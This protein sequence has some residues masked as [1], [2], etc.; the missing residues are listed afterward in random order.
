[1]SVTKIVRLMDIQD[2]ILKNNP[3]ANIE[4]LHMGYVYAAQ[5]HRGQ[6]RQ[7]GEAY[8]S[9]PLNVAYILAEMKMDVDSI[10][11]GLL[12]DTIEDTST[13]YE[14]IEE[15]FGKEVA[16]LVEAVTKISKIPFQSKEEKQ[17][18]SFRKML[19]SMSDD[20]RVII[21]K[22]ADRLHNMRTIDSLREDKQKRIA[23]ET[24]DI[25]A[26][27]ADRLGIAWIKW[28]LED[29]A[30]RILTPDM[31]YEI[32]QKVKLKRTE[33]EQYL[34][35]VQD[36]VKDALD[37]SGIKGEISGRPKHFYSIYSKMIKKKTSFEEIFDL[38]ALRV[39]VATKQD[40]YSALGIIHSLWTPIPHRIKDFIANPKANMYQSLHTTV[41]GPGGM[42]VEF[43]IRTKD[44]HQIAEEG[45][46]AHWA[47]KEGR[48]FNPKEDSRFGWLRK[49]LEEDMRNQ[50]PT[51]FVN[52]IKEDVF[53]NQIYV[54]TPKGH[55]VELPEGSTPIDFAYAIHSEV[56][57]KCVG[58]KIN[59][60][61][62]PLK[63]KL[64]S[65]DK[66][67]IMTSQTQE[68]RKDWLNIVQT[69]RARQRI[70]AHLR[71]KESELAIS[72][73][74]ELLNKA[75]K[76]VSLDAESL[77][78]D[79]KNFKKVADKF[80]LKTLEELY[81]NVGFGQISPKK[82]VHL[83]KE[84]EPEDEQDSQS[85]QKSAP[86]TKIEPFKI[87]GIDNMMMKTAKCCN[88]LPGDEVRGYIS[89]GRGIVVHKSD[90]P[91]LIKLAEKPDRIVD[92]EWAN[93]EKYQAP[94]RFSAYVEDKPGVFVDVST[95]IKDMG[96]NIYEMTV[97]N[98]GDGTSKM[99]FTVMVSDKKQA[100]LL[101]AKIIGVKGI[102]SVKQS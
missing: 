28:E 93:G 99:D 55:V 40:C 37:K 73:G 10:V 57:D 64:V 9:H 98:D 17:A 61:I 25:Y 35:E 82:V 77:L 16:F 13:T 14:V 30:F 101:S 38:L 22:L 102:L 7:S 67:E 74:R 50:T 56:G 60:R 43:Q 19:I 26:P 85:K 41:M 15:M 11:A 75:F 24:M 68:P 92:V 29:R 2:M 36:I 45:I 21:I 94:V 27:L 86:K 20:V 88:P 46:A 6:L 3:D 83:F 59:G 71:K 91:N 96:L 1:M 53:Q 89:A 65:G 76:A 80:A 79:D 62:V 47:Y 34:T 78:N 4:K 66:V 69:S 70:S 32:H 23:R 90:C 63:A 12:H 51:D 39:I 5:Q 72:T 81:N 31:Y 95:V 8:L 33:R 42:M 52:T 87:D 100:E 58:A 48:V 84:D 44:M 97:K 18:E 54:F 49:I